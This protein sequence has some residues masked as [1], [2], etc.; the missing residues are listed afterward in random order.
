MNSLEKEIETIFLDEEEKVLN[1]LKSTYAKSLNDVKTYAKKLQDDLN[2]LLD[3]VD[4]DDENAKSLIRSKV[5]QIEYQ[6]QLAKQI[7]GYMNVITD[8]NIKTI[9]DYLNIMYNE[10]FLTQNYALNKQGV[11]VIMPINQKLLIKAITYNTDN[12]PLS[13]RLYS[14]VEKA[15]KDIIAEISRGLSIGASTADMAR[16]LENTMGVSFRKAY[17]IAQNEGARVREESIIDSL[18]EAKRKGADI[19]KRWSATL[20]GKTRPVHREL[21]G[22]WVELEDDFEYSGG[23]VFAP[24][25]FG[26]PSE[27]INCRCTLI[28]VP[29]WE[30]E[31]TYVKRDNESKGLVKVKNYEDWYENYYKPKQPKPTT[32]TISE[33]VTTSTPTEKPLTTPIATT[34]AKKAYKSYS[35]FSAKTVEV[36]DKLKEIP[37]D[38]PKDKVE[39]MLRS[40]GFDENYLIGELNDKLKNGGSKNVI[41]SRS[42]LSYIISRHGS[43]FINADVLLN[44]TS[45]LSDYDVVT[46]GKSQ[47]DGDYAFYKLF[48]SEGYGIEM[49]MNKISDES[50]DYIVHYLMVSNKHNR[51]TKML[52]KYLKSDTYVDKKE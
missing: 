3:Q 44:I 34:E 36:W 27:D 14:N 8:K 1:K 42:N 22:K 47:K 35:D 20:D 52:N 25:Q 26:I 21:E 16:N 7:E 19:V 37:K 43:D 24:K 17:Q 13:K 30:L 23:K 49:K 29:R 11:G 5:Y 51:A 40:M 28:G 2:K 10:G 48:E 12:I 46:K 18:Y 33:V 4:E 38:T 31:D 41:L 45:V 39:E 6:K 32:R 15:K 9:S 50:D